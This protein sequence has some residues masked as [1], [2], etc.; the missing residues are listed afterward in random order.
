MDRTDGTDEK[1]VQDRS[2]YLPF[3]T[4]AASNPFEGRDLRERR[5]GAGALSVLQPAGGRG[6]TWYQG[7]EALRTLPS[8][9]RVG[10]GRRPDVIE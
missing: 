8:L 9:L 4:L 10:G 1:D 2:P 3:G 5:T 7:K 6:F